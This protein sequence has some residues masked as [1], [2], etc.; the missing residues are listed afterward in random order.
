MPPEQPRDS[1]WSRCAH[2]H[3]AQQPLEALIGNRE[4]AS[5]DQPTRD[6]LIGMRREH[7]HGLRTMLEEGQRQGVFTVE[8]AHV[9]TFAIL[10][11]G[12]S[13]ARWFRPDGPLSADEAGDHYANP[14]VRMCGHE[15]T[16]SV[17]R[18]EWWTRDGSAGVVAPGL[19]CRQVP[20]RPAT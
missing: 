7:E 2:N 19:A 18:V 14:A 12:V 15:G 3:H 13:V 8:H 10:E 5:L 11:M 4:A 17:T 16:A 9:T 1:S 6:E 20:E